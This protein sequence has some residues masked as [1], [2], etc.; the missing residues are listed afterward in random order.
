MSLSPLF[1]NEM[2]RELAFHRFSH[3]R[4]SSDFFSDDTRECGLFL[5]PHLLDYCNSGIFIHTQLLS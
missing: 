3:G 4:D 1:F 2:P 5:Y